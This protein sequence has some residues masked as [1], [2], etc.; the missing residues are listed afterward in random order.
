MVEPENADSG[1]LID[2]HTA[3]SRWHGERMDMSQAIAAMRSKEGVRYYP[4]RLVSVALRRKAL[5]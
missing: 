2:R 5:P 1:I 4:I 3:R